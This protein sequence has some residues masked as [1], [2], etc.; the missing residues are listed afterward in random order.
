MASIR[1]SPLPRQNCKQRDEVRQ[2]LDK[3]GNQSAVLKVKHVISLKLYSP[4]PHNQDVLS[5]K[6]IEVDDDA[7]I[8]ANTVQCSPGS[9]CQ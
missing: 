6:E 8:T 7:D 1:G 5:S 9:R 4:V 3:A 2:D